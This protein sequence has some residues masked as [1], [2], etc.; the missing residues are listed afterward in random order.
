MMNGLLNGMNTNDPDWVWRSFLLLRVTKL[1]LR[2]TKCVT[3]F[4]YIC[5]YS[6]YWLSR[7]KLCAIPKEAL[8]ILLDVFQQVTQK[9]EKTE[10]W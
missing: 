4:L 1:L 10:V 9:L 6:C 2:V 3:Q 5:R 8:L 7:V